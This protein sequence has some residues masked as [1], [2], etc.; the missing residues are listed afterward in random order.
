[1]TVECGIS[2]KHTQHKKYAQYTELLQCK[3]LQIFYIRHYGSS[4]HI[5]NSPTQIR[6][7]P[8]QRKPPF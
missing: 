3:I 1:M 6:T 5:T 4:L 8:E 7:I 2:L